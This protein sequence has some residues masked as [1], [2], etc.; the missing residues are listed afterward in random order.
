MSD[1]IEMFVTINKIE[2]PLLFDK[3]QAIHNRQQRS[4]VLKQLATNGLLFT[5]QSAVSSLLVATGN[6][7]E[8]RAMQKRHEELPS[9]TPKQP[10]LPITAATNTL[11]E[12]QNIPP[13]TV[14]LAS[15]GFQMY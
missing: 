1:H 2:H 11:D 3:L 13:L 9:I 7:A 12:D 10:P 5:E 4:R 8:L 6:S 14:D 15:L